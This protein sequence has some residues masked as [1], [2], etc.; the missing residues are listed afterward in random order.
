MYNP[1]CWEI[2]G[3]R[4]EDAMQALIDWYNYV[5]DMATNPFNDEFFA[6]G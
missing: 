4:Y 6:W 3:D 2:M 5:A 1:D